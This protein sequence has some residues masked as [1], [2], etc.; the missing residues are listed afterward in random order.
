MCYVLKKFKTSIKSSI[1]F[2]KIH[3]FI[4]FHQK[5][6]LKKYVKRTKGQRKINEI[7]LKNIFLFFW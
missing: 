1:S 7:T 3:R 2:E 5:V 6:L 4:K